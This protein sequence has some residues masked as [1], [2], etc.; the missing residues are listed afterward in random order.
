MTA[1]FPRPLLAT[2]ADSALYVVRPAVDDP[3]RR[4]LR[5]G[6]NVLIVGDHGSGRTSLLHAHARELREGHR[7]V[8]YID[9]RAP[10]AAADIVRAVG[11]AIEDQGHPPRAIGRPAADEEGVLGAL[12]QLPDARDAIVLL[13]DPS[14]DD[15]FELFGRHRDRLWETD[16]TWVVATTPEGAALL[17]APP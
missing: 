17:A 15:A 3:L 4:A 11:L 8:V 10:D 6:R 2:R 13:D 9:G 16:Y 5:L 12:R 1:L 14:P 7:T